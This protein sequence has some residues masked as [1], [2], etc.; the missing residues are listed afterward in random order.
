MKTRGESSP[1]AWKSPFNEMPDVPFRIRASKTPLLASE[2][3]VNRR[4]TTR[5][6]RFLKSLGK[7]SLGPGLADTRGSAGSGSETLVVNP[8]SRGR[9]P[10]KKERSRDFDRR[11]DAM[12]RGGGRAKGVAE[13]TDTVLTPPLGRL[14]NFR[15]RTP[16][17]YHS[18]AQT[19]WHF[20]PGRL[21]LRHALLNSPAK[22]WQ[23]LSSPR[24]R[25]RHSPAPVA[26]FIHASSSTRTPPVRD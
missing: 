14:F 3:I 2:T 19:Y 26:T 17:V 1:T 23:P 4:A 8:I 7:R 20:A 15:R 10:R 22:L 25:L 16:E 9:S 12:T 24:P 13:W 6:W 11:Y 5:G 18:A 21:E